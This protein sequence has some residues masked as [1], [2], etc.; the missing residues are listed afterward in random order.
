MKSVQV[1]WVLLGSMVAV[2]ACAP[3]LQS[4]LG[5]GM[6]VDGGVTVG[7]AF[8]TQAAAKTPGQ[9]DHY[10]YSLYNTG[11]TTVA[12]TYTTVATTCHFASVPDGTYKLQA[13]AFDSGNASITQGGAKL[14]TNTATVASPSVTYSAGNLLVNLPLLDATGESVA[15]SVTSSAGNAWTGTPVGG[16]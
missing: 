1:L 10:T 8:G 12:A 11:T 9:I 14:G 4:P 2:A 3:V 15:N 6:S 5:K 13:E 16:P 7:G